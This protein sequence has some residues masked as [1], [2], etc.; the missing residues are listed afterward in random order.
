MMRPIPFPAPTQSPAMIAGLRK[1]ATSLWLR[2]L[3]HRNV[4][5]SFVAGVGV[6]L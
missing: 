5:R 4:R 3:R 2:S 1:I 6:N